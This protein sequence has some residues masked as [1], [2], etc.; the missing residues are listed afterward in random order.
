MVN[1]I[2]Q[3]VEAAKAGETVVIFPE[4]KL[5]RNGGLHAF[6]AGFQR[7]AQRAGVPIIPVHIHG[8]YGSVLS[9]AEQ[10]SARFRPLVQF[11]LVSHWPQDTAPAEAHR[12]SLV[13]LTNQPVQR[14]ANDQRHLAEQMFARG[15]A[16]I[17]GLSL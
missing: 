16:V 14:A 7:I 10:R 2:E 12:V 15:L 5:T 8:M 6:S 13:W 11:G 9:R 4:G 3:A 1:S 17:H